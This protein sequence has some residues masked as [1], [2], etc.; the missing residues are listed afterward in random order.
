MGLNWKIKEYLDSIL[1][2]KCRKKVIVE[3]HS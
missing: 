2:Q 3:D 1:K